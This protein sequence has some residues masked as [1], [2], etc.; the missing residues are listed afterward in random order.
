MTSYNIG[1]GSSGFAY[2]T[3]RSAGV[4]HLPGNIPNPN[5]G[6]N[7]ALE[8]PSKLGLQVHHENNLRNDRVKDNSTSGDISASHATNPHNG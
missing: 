8:Q 7:D 3:P 4:A 1:G 2:P 6:E 5:L